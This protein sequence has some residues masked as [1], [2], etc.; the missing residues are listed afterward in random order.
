MPHID[1]EGVGRKPVRVKLPCLSLGA[2]LLLLSWP[3]IATTYYVAESSGDDGNTGLSHDQAWRELDALEDHTFAPGDKVLFLCGDVWNR[4]EG[5]WGSGETDIAIGDVSDLTIG[6]YYLDGATPREVDGT[7]ATCPGDK[8]VFDGN[9]TSHSGGMSSP[10][11]SALRITANSDHVSVQDIKVQNYHAG[12]QARARDGNPGP[13]TNGVFRRLE[14]YNTGRYGIALDSNPRSA[15]NVSGWTVAQCKIIRSY[16]AFEGEG[17][18]GIALSLKHADDYEVYG[19]EVGQTHGEGIAGWGGADRGEIYDNLVYETGSVSIYLSCCHDVNVHHNYVAGTTDAYWKQGLGRTL[20]GI[21]FGGETD[22][23]GYVDSSGCV[24][25]NNVV[26]G[27]DAGGFSV[28]DAND[29]SDTTADG[30]YGT[31]YVYANTFIDNDANFWMWNNDGGELTITFANNLSIVNDTA[32]SVHVSANLGPH[33]TWLGNGWDE[34]TAVA[35]GATHADDVIGDPAIVNEAPC[36]AGWNQCP[37]HDVPSW[38]DA[39]LS[40]GSDFIDRAPALADEYGQGLD[41]ASGWPGAVIHRPQA[42]YG[43]GWEYG[44]YVNVYDLCASQGGECCAESQVCR[45]GTT[46]ALDNCE[47]CCFD[48]SCGPAGGAGGAGGV[49][50]TGGGSAAG[51]A[52]ANAS[53]PNTTG[54]DGGCGCRL[55]ARRRPPVK[56]GWWLVLLG[57]GMGARAQRRRPRG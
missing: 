20:G 46:Q 37:S 29:D 50:A 48:G 53:G 4:A 42:S 21:G 34:S 44:A 28:T 6:A 7:S 14:T 41:P 9:V 45:D 33:F 38:G 36:P 22:E 26:F 39:A 31:N 11:F 2:T 16:M 19:N 13:I 10:Y 56:M 49:G 15:D 23:M 8:P 24:F 43:A 54:D 32:N 5:D 3:A 1:T 40:S 55:P 12:F 30:G 27:R 52:G 35:A 18:W 47:Q 25:H 17:G 57:V 51:G